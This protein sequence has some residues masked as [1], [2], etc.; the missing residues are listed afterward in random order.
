MAGQS[1][2]KALKAQ[3]KAKSIM[4][5][6]VVGVNLFYVIVRLAL[7][8][9]TTTKWHFIALVALNVVYAMTF[10]AALEASSAPA[11]SITEYFFDLFVIALVSQG[12]AALTAKGWYLLLL[13]PAFLLY[14]AGTYF[15]ASSG[16]KTKIPASQPEEEADDRKVKQK[17]MK[18][19]RR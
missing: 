6:C 5:P 11:G 8:Y 1:A 3:Q 15:F 18:S 13:V 14:K 16:A 17:T 19:R 4:L 2:K 10:P 7:R 9:A 12:L